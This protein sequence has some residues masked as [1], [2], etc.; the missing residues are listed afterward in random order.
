MVWQAPFF[1]QTALKYILLLMLPLFYQ[2]EI[3]H[4]ALL[5]DDFSI[6]LLYVY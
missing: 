5:E 2:S 6:S 1:S 3:L 4:K